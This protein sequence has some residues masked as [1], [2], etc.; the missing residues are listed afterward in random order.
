[1]LPQKAVL[2]AS[3]RARLEKESSAQI[4]YTSQPLVDFPIIPFQIFGLAYDLDIVIVTD[5]PKI[6][7]HEFVKIAFPDGEVWITK[8]SEK[9]TLDQVIYTDRNDL[10]K[11][12]PEIPLRIISTPVKV[13]DQSNGKNYKFQFEYRNRDGEEVSA[14]FEGKSNL[15]LLKK[16]NGSTMGHSRNQVIAVLDLPKRSLGKRSKV[17][18][19]GI[20][21][22][23]KKI[24]GIKNFH[25]AVQQTQ[26]GLSVASIEM[27]K[28]GGKIA[29]THKKVSKDIDQ[30]WEIENGQEQVNL[31]QQNAVR[32]I[33]YCYHKVGEELHFFKA[34]L[35]FWKS[36]D[37]TMSISVFP[38]MPDLRRKF[39]RTFNGKFIIDVNGQKSH[40]FGDI[41][42]YWEADQLV[43]DV[44]PNSPWWIEERPM[45]GVI[46]IE[47]DAVSMNFGMLQGS[48]PTREN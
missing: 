8:E 46:K 25:T 20:H 10:H 30:K 39:S 12:F 45:R 21:Y 13:I 26:A 5:H 32:K 44:L 38:D 23:T 2:S 41:L 9:G 11:L 33:K 29:T 1:M 6:D 42:C 3:E 40:G 19:D 47:N 48:D 34:S 31:I 15:K 27:K 28:S 22:K 18:Y 36:D 4:N 35:S 7:M 43:V 24:I 16:R 17:T 37:G 14:H